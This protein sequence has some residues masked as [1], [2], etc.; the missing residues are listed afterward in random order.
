[1]HFTQCSMII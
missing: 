1:M